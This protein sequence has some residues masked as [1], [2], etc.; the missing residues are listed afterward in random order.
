MNPG[1]PVTDAPSDF[2][3]GENHRRRAVTRWTDH[4][5]VYRPR[6]DFGRQYVFDG[7]I[8]AELCSRVIQ[9]I[10]LVF[11]RH[12]GDIFERNPIGLHVAGLLK[13]KD[14]EQI[15]FERLLG[16]V[17]KDRKKSCLRMG[18]AAR[19]FFLAY[20]QRGIEQPGGHVKPRLRHGIDSGA[21][22]D[23]AAQVR[24][25]P[26]AAAVRKIFAFHV[27]PVE[28]VRSSAEHNAVDLI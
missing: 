22:T 12:A 7:E 25:L 4:E 11:D 26:A 16:N 17:V 27:H 20:H 10:A 24:F 18:K 6:H 14:P 1:G 15:R 13:R 3:S 23:V 2:F 28:S 8:R 19:H 9:C 21:A 5:P